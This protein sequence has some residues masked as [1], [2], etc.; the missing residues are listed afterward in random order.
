MQQVDKDMGLYCTWGRVIAQQENIIQTHRLLGPKTT[1]VY[2][3]REGSAG[4]PTVFQTERIVQDIVS[5][6]AKIAAGREYRSNLEETARYIAAG[7]PGKY[8]FIQR[9]WWTLPNAPV[10]RRIGLVTEAL[11]FLESR[12]RDGFVRANR[13][14]YRWRDKIYDQLG[15][16]LG[17]KE[18]EDLA[19]SEGTAS[20]S[21]EEH[22]T[23]S[24]GQ[25]LGTIS[26]Y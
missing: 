19:G 16:V 26:R 21:F 25:Y 7:D 13:S 18:G 8:T 3:L 2:E 6:E 5:A 14:F 24:S 20:Y 17:Y 4:G 10:R 15:I 22:H 9:Y 1:P 11:P 23:R 12:S